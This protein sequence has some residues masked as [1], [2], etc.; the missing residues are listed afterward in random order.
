MKSTGIWTA[1]VV[2]VNETT[3]E[4]GCVKTR[5]FPTLLHTRF[6]DILEIHGCKKGSKKE[7]RICEQDTVVSHKIYYF[8]CAFSL[9][10]SVTQRKFSK[11][12]LKKKEKKKKFNSL[13]M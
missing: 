1:E 8:I 13:H 7:Q 3:L 10:K 2:E 5:V 6:T 11:K 4:L 9:K 12:N